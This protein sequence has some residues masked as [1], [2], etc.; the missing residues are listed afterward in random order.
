MNAQS[1]Y[2]TAPSELQGKPYRGTGK[3]TGGAGFSLIEAL[4]AVSVASI[5]LLAAYNT[6]AFSERSL[7]QS[8]PRTLANTIA[9]N[10]AALMRILPPAEHGGLPQDAQIGPYAWSISRHPVEQAGTMSSVEI[11]VQSPD[12]AGASARVF[13]VSAKN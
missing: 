12:H 13:L 9:L 8:I 6:I 5:A 11:V 2:K 7:G 3:R 10:Q 4:V 1:L